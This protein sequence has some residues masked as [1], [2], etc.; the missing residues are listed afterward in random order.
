VAIKRVE[1][2]SKLF[3][4]NKNAGYK[5]ASKNLDDDDFRTIGAWNVIRQP[6]LVKMRRIRKGHRLVAHVSLYN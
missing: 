1:R 3:H 4:E 6:F 2:D 5:K